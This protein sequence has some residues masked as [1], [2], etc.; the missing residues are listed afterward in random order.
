MPDESRT[1][2]V[3][4]L[5]I[6][7]A[8]L[9]M[10]MGL[11]AFFVFS[12]QYHNYHAGLWALLSFILSTVV[13]HQHMLYSNFRLEDWH[14]VHSLTALRNLGILTIFSSLGATVYYVYTAVSEGQEV[15][16]IS[17]SLLIAGVWGFMSFKWSV[18]TI[19]YSQ[20]YKTI[21]DREYT[22]F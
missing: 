4:K 2:C 5:K 18:A 15:Y 6:G 20:K 3:M 9:G 10:L 12:I 1:G 14:T 16:P 11:S 19:F 21:L 8:G 17:D 7:S 13:F 22:L